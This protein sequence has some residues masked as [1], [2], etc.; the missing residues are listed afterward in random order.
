MNCF[1]YCFVGKKRN[2]I[3]AKCGQREQESRGRAGGFSET[4][5]HKPTQSILNV[6]YFM[7]SHA[8]LSVLRRPLF[9]CQ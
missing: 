2:Y 9:L 8:A 6:G 3:A 7:G 4:V 5:A 1:Q